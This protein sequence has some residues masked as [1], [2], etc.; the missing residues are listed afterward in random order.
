[1]Y[2]LKYG[3]VTKGEKGQGIAIKIISSEMENHTSMVLNF[4]LSVSLRFDSAE[5]MVIRM[6]AVNINVLWIAPKKAVS[7]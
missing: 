1:M 7:I 6:I 2:H 4:S 3:L 5:P